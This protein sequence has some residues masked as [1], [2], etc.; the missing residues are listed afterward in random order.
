MLS[1]RRV[2]RLFR[3]DRKTYRYVAHGRDNTALRLRLKELAA[4][5]VRFGYRRLYVLLRR[6]GWN[7]NHKRVYRIY[8]EEELTVRTKQ[9]KKIASRARLVLPGATAPNERWSMDFVSD[10]LVD[11]RA[12]RVLT[13]VDQ[14]SRFCPILEPDQN[15]TGQKVAASLDRAAKDHGYPKA[16]TVDNGS[17]FYSRAMDAWAYRHGVQL[18]FIRPGKPV[19]NGFIESFNGRLR[20]ECL[21][22]D[23]FFSI[24]DARQKLETWR[25]DYNEV[26]PHSSLADATPAK[27]QKLLFALSSVNT[28]AGEGRQGN[29]SG[30]RNA[31]GLDCPRLLPKTTVNRAKESYEECAW[32]APGACSG[33]GREAAQP[34]PEAGFLKSAVE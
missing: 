2:C 10:R 19:E 26:R 18:Q 33:S 4:A 7:V 3:L 8:L 23:L 24:P 28:A 17:E 5:R 32:T 1:E 15:L 30:A 22:V 16:I 13:V 6:E 31:R 27:Y 21:N 9:R 12:F 20:D 34:D 29:P 11:G 25:R 14:F